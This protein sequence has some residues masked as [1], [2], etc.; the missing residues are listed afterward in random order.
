[1]NEVTKMERQEVLLNE[2]AAATPMAMIDRALQSGAGIE[3]IEKLLAL[4]ERWEAGKARR[5]FDAAISAARA[6][7]KPIVKSSEVDFTSSKGRTH[8][9]HETLDGIAQQID[10]ILGK[11]GL[12]YRFRSMQ[13]KGQLFVT[14]IVAHRDGYSEDT[15]LSG[16]PDQSGSKNPYQAIGSAATYLQRYTLKLA[17]GL[18]AS[19]DDDAQA[20]AHEESQ[21]QSISSDQFI[22]LRD[23]AEQ[24]GVSEDRLCQTYGASSLELFPADLFQTAVRK[25]DT[26]IRAKSEVVTDDLGGDEI[27]Y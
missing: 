23:K 22:K 6:E 11:Y 17:L 13:D 20:V 1:M 21:S 5:A 24:A 19:K 10:P 2:P 9:K 26:T 18:S 4:Q 15:T 3:T 12:S 27:P 25:L 8:Y 7:I 14:C 16:P